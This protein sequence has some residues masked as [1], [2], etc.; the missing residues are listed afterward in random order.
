[1]DKTQDGSDSDNNTVDFQSN[2]DPTPGY[3]NLQG[4]TGGSVKPSPDSGCGKNPDEDGPN[5]CSSVST[6]PN[7]VWIIFLAVFLRRKE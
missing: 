1:M 4:G 3:A 6:Y 2:M 7:A 5:K